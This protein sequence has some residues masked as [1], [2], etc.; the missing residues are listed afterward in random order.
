MKFLSELIHRAKSSLKPAELQGKITPVRLVHGTGAQQA[1]DFT[2]RTSA[3][4]SAGVP[5]VIRKYS[6]TPG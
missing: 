5:I 6:F 4:A 3:A 1:I 2:A